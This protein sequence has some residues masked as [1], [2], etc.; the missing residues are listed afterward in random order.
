MPCVQRA[1][2][3]SA[4]IGVLSNADNPRYAFDDPKLSACFVALQIGQYCQGEWGT[5]T[6]GAFL[7]SVF[8]GFPIGIVLGSVVFGVVYWTCRLMGTIAR[9]CLNLEPWDE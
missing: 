5:S 8:V 9:K 4:F 1:G 2:Y 7:I 3:S 6:L